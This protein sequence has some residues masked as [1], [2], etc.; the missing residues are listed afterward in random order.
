M[1]SNLLYGFAGFVT[2]VV[3]RRDKLAQ[4]VLKILIQLNIK[5]SINVAKILTGM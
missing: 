5:N 3:A 2:A 1:P 4:Q